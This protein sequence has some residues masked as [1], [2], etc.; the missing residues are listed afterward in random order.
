MSAKKH[1]G[2]DLQ[3]AASACSAYG[4]IVLENIADILRLA[5]PACF[6]AAQT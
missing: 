5:I 1:V 2:I 3:I 6:T 4:T